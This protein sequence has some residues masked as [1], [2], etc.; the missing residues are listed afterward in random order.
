MRF[1]SLRVGDIVTVRNKTVEVVSLKDWADGS[2]T[3]N[4]KGHGIVTRKAN[5]L[6]SSI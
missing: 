1:K 2:R 3:I 5:V 6:L 4:F